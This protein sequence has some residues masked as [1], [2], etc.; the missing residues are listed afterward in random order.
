VC[1]PCQAEDDPQV[2]ANTNATRLWIHALGN[3]PPE[4]SVMAS[5]RPILAFSATRN[6][7]QLERR[8]IRR[9]RALLT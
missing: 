1:W 9:S 2:S 7:Y 6:H 5:W 3:L 8:D 4:H